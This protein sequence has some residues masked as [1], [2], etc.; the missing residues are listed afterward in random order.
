MSPGSCLDSSNCR[1]ARLLRGAVAARAPFVRK[2]ENRVKTPELAHTHVEAVQLDTEMDRRI[3]LAAVRIGEVLIRGVAVWRSRHGKLRVFFPSYRLG[4][5]WD[6]AIYLPPDL[7]TQ[8]E[9]E[10]IAAF[11]AARSAAKVRAEKTGA[12]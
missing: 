5:G 6:E 1:V 7:R 10:V 12:T 8:V 3:A 2:L 4:A 11:K 9:A